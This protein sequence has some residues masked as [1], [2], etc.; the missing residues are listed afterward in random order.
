MYAAE[1][2]EGGATLNEQDI[3]VSDTNELI[4]ALLASNFSDERGYVPVGFDLFGRFANLVWGVTR[5]GSAG[6]NMYYVAA[7][8]LDRCY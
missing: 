5:L 2:G 6:L 7:G 8:Q 1:Y 4:R 3:R